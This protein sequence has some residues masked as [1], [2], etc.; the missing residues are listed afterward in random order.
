MA[1][2]AKTAVIEWIFDQRYDPATRVLS[3]TLVT[4][5]DITTAIR[6][7]GSTLRSNNPANFWK[8]LTRGSNGVGDKW[9]ASVRERGYLGRTA[10]GGGDQASFEFI[11]ESE[12]TSTSLEIDPGALAASTHKIQAV[13]MPL[14]MR[15]LGR[16]DEN[17]IAQVVARL[18]VVET[19]FTL[20]ST[21]LVS[22]IAFLQTG[23]KLRTGEID[24]AYSMVDESGDLWLLS[25]EVKRSNE[26]LDKSQ[27]VRAAN[28]LRES[29]ATRVNA[30]GVIPVLVKAI[31]VDGAP[32]IYVAEFE[33]VLSAS[34]ELVRV[35]EGLYELTPAVPG[36]S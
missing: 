34:D 3:A 15:A 10:I 31:K 6:E 13:S 16:T 11:P 33:S 32:R 17:W 22:E 1:R 4:F 12:Y 21:H 14:A 24:A 26:G 19:H 9:P 25:V 30:K 20:H 5:D 2:S 18:S 36:V 35:S 29:Y 28:G 27:L 23:I 7:S 8:D